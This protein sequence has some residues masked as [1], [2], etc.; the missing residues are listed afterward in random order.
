M[1]EVAAL[2]SDTIAAI[3]TPLGEGG[4]AVIR[5]SGKEAI[6]LVEPLVRTKQKLSEVP[7]HTVHYGFVVDPANGEKVDEVLV[8]VMRAPKTFTREDVVE[9]SCHG[10]ILPVKKVLDL[11]LKHG[12]RLAEPGEFTKRAFLNGRIDLSQAEAVMDLIRSKSDRAYAQALKQVDGQLSRKVRELRQLLVELMAHIEVN[13]DYPEHDVEEVTNRT[14][15][16]HCERALVQIDELLKTAERGKILREGVVTAIIGRPNAGKSSLLNLLAR[17]N[18]AIVTDIPGTTRD[19]IEEYVNVAGIPLKLLDTAGLRETDDVVEQIGVERSLQALSQADLILLVLNYNERLNEEERRIIEQVRT[20]QSLAII[21][22]KD[23]PR[24]LEMEEVYAAFPPE[25]VVEMSV[26]HEDG[27][28][29]LEKAIA[30]MFFSGS[31]QGQDLS[32]VSNARHIAELEQA[33][34]CLKE[35]LAAAEQLVPIDMIQID[36]RRAWEHLGE[37]IGE[38]VSESLID[39]IFSQFCLGK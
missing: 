27:V 10:G 36:V 17:E 32:Y 7:S 33:K 15:R 3:S 5:V 28:E 2:I 11:L 39:Q 37:I 34:A 21:N 20:R 9:I 35:A 29:R 30:D 1:I 31:I 12:I 18:R 25:R 19:V 22:K 23:L 4:I 13:I 8:T 6:Q 24:Q 26:L 14:I 38:N 16:E